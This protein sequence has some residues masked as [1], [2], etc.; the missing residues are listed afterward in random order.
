VPINPEARRALEVLW[1]RKDEQGYVCR[2]GPRWFGTVI[3]ATD[4]RDFHWHDLRH[5][6]ASRLVIS[7]ADIRT[8]LELLGDR[9]VSMAM[10]YSHRT[11]GHLKTAVDRMAIVFPKRTDTRTDIGETTLESQASNSF[12]VN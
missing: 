7:G 8:L 10:R 12:P 11:P 5:T 1:N 9:T 6:F 3:R 2:R 4:V